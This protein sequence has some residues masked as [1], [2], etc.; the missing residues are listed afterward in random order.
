MLAA[1][2]EG[3]GPDL[4]V[5]LRISIGERSPDGLT[6]VESI[7]CLAALDRDGLV[8][9][10]SVVAGTSATLAGSDHIVPPMTIP[11][12]YT[13]PLSVRVKEAV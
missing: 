8:D 10:V 5:G 1:V 7:D 11:N 3:V 12:A 9:Y 4:A 13:V 6:P 2:R